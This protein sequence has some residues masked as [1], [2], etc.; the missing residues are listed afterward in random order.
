[1][2]DLSSRSPP[3]RATS[4]FVKEGRD[5][6]KE[7]NEGKTWKCS[8]VVGMQQARAKNQ[9]LHTQNMFFLS[10][11]SLLFRFR[12]PNPHTQPA[13]SPLVHSHTHAA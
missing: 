1:M 8:L 5:W 4:D 9:F 12:P 11:V 7:A 3:T 10:S 13:R 2:R 6:W